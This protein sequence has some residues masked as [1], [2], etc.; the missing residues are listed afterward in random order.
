MLIVTWL[1]FKYPSVRVRH[2]NNKGLIMEVTG[3]PQHAVGDM[4]VVRIRSNKE[5]EDINKKTIPEEE[6]GTVGDVELKF[7]KKFMK[8]QDHK[9]RMRIDHASQGQILQAKEQGNLHET[10]L[11]RREKI[12]SDRMCK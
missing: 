3:E 1:C 6:R 8:F 7:T 5:K 9:Y 2:V 12:K 10:L 4:E 11:D